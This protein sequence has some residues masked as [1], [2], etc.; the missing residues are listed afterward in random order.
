MSTGGD[1]GRSGAGPGGV[2]FTSA[3]GLPS[4]GGSS[5]GGSSGAGGGGTN[6]CNPAPDTPVK[7][8][9]D[10]GLDDDLNG[11][12]DENC[13]CGSGATQQCFNGPP[14][15]ASAPNCHKGTQAC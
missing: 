7:E 9:C 3:G 2:G 6:N 11:F 13:R 4:G 8:V 14:S 1:P 5:G 10:N 12:V 15:Q